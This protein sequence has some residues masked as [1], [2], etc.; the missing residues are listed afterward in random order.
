MIETNTEIYING[1]ILGLFLGAL[2]LAIAY[3]IANNYFKREQKR[4][5]LEDRLNNVEK[6]LKVR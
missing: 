6:K 2:L 5:E 4:L 1:M 3:S